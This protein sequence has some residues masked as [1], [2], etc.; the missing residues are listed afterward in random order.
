M[1]NY[2]VTDTE[3]TSIANAIRTKGGTSESLAFPSG[4]VSAIDE[5]SSGNGMDTLI[6]GSFSG[7][8]SASISFVRSCAFYSYQS[9]TGAD[10]PNCTSIGSSAFYCC[11][12][13]A[14]VSI[15]NCTSIGSYA[16]H[17]CRALSGLDLPKVT[18]VGSIGTFSSAFSF[19]SVPECTSFAMYLGSTTISV[20]SLPKCEYIGNVSP[21]TNWSLKKVYAPQCV[22]LSGGFRSAYRLSDIYF[23]K[24]ETISGQAFTQTAIVNAS[25]PALKRIVGDAYNPAAFGNCQS[26]VEGSFPELLLIGANAFRSCTIAKLYFPKVSSVLGYA[27]YG[28]SSLRSVSFQAPVSFGYYAFAA[29]SNLSV[30]YFQSNVSFAT[31]VFAGCSKLESVY[32]LGDSVGTLSSSVFSS[33]PMSNSTYLSRF[34]SLYVPASLLT[35]YQSAPY[36][37]AYSARFASIDNLLRFSWNTQF[38]EYQPADLQPHE[39]LPLMEDGEVIIIELAD[40]GDRF[41]LEYDASDAAVGSYWGNGKLTDDGGVH[42]LQLEYVMDGKY[43]DTAGKMIRI[44]EATM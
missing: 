40:K 6:D 35:A 22:T 24:L 21:G 44:I 13:L 27:F 36:W 14:S 5:I 33:T 37:S 39:I 8:Y 16:F 15:P 7:K 4:F 30:V 1:A 31:S 20:L 28:C 43:T 3:L 26:L 2:T 25:F 23:P 11:S 10:L 19:I 41:V 38:D 32:F 42:N 18:S 29:C 9:I 34:G 17:Y 12:S